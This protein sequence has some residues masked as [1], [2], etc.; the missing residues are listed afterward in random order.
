MDPSTGRSSVYLGLY[1]V[2]MASFNNPL[3]LTLTIYTRAAVLLWFVIFVVVGWAPAVLILFGVVDMA[4]AT[5]TYLAMK[6]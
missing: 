1:Y 6:K 2:F 5:W 4:G 3:F